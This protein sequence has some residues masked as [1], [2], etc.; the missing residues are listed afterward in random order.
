[1]LD[2]DGNGTFGIP[3]Y[4]GGGNGPAGLAVDDFNRDRRP[5]LAVATAATDDVSI[6]LNAGPE[7][8]R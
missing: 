8:L 6:L 7:P 1:V 2:N 4:F 3:R 5:D